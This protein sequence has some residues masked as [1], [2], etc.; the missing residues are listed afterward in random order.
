MTTMRSFRRV[1]PLRLVLSAGAAASV[2][3]ASAL[4]GP[5]NGH[6]VHGQGSISQNG[7]HTTV[8]AGNNSIFHWGS[9]SIGAGESVRFVQPGSNSRVLNRVTGPDPSRIAGQLSANGR[10]YIVNPAGVYFARGAVVNVG[11]IYAAAGSIS[12]AAFLSGSNTFTGLS[13][14]VE[15]RGTITGS[16]VHLI[17]QRVANYGTI[18][19]PEGMVALAAGEEVYVGKENGQI[20][21]KVTSGAQNSGGVGVTQAG[22]IDARGGQVA[23]GAGDMYAVAIHHTGR[24]T[25]KNITLEGG[26]KRG[27][28]QVA[29]VLDAANQGEEQ[30]GGTIKVLGE[31][32]GITGGTLDASGVHGGGTILVGGEYQGRG[33]TPTATRTVVSADSTLN[34]E[35]TGRGDGG[36]IIVWSDQTTIYKGDLSVRGGAAGGHGGFAEVSGKQSLF[37][38]GSAMTHSRAGGRDG[39]LLLDPR[40]IT[41]QDGV[42]PDDGEVS[43]SEILFGDGGAATDFVIGTDALEALTG[44]ILLQAQRDLTLLAGASLILA[45]QTAGESLTFIAGNDIN[46]LASIQTA[47]GSVI[48]RANDNTFGTATGTGVI[49]IGAQ[50]HAD[51]GDITL[52]GSAINLGADLISVGGHTNFLSPVVLTENVTLEAPAITFYSTLDSEATEFNTLQL[53]SGANSFRGDVGAAGADT[54]LGILTTNA[55]GVTAIDT[56]VL[57]AQTIAFNDRVVIQQDVTISASNSLI[58]GGTLNSTADEFNDL[59]LN[60]PS[61]R[62]NGV[63]GTEPASRLGTLATDA[64]GTLT[65]AAGSIHAD[66]LTIR[67]DVVLEEDTTLTAEQAMTIVGTIDSAGGETNDLTLDA[68]A[69]A[70][71]G[72]IGGTDALGAFATAGGVAFLNAGAITADTVE[73]GGALD[74]GAD[75]TITGATS[76][77]FG[78]IDSRAG[79]THDLTVNSPL[80]TFAGAAGANE[81]LGVVTTDA[82]GTTTLSQ[83]SIEAAEIRFNDDVEVGGDLNTLTGTTIVRF[84]GLVDGVG[85]A[86][87]QLTVNS[88]QTLF[89]GPIGSTNRLGELTTDAAGTT[90][91][92][93]GSIAVR[94]A[95]FEDTVVFTTDAV[96]NASGSMR[97]EGA[98]NSEAGEANTLTVQ[99]GQ[100]FFLSGL[101]AGTDGEFGTLTGDAPVTLGGEVTTTGSQVYNNAVRLADDT[102]INA[103]EIIFNAT[104]NSLSAD[105]ALTL[106]TSGNGLTRF[107]ANVGVVN[108]LASLTTNADGTT[109][110]NLGSLVASGEV[111]FNDPLLLAS[112]ATVFGGDITFDQTVDSL[113]TSNS[114]FV[115]TSGSGVTTFAG[116]VGGILALASLTTNPLGTTRIEGGAVTTTGQQ[117]YN[118]DVVITA[119]TTLTGSGVAFGKTLNSG[120]DPRSLTIRTGA[121]GTTTFGGAVGNT[122]Q[123]E[124]ITVNPDVTGPSTGIIRISGPTIRTSGD[125]LYNQR[126]VLG[127]DAAFTG[128]DISFVQ[129]LDSTLLLGPSDLT[130]N[131]TGGGITRLFGP[132]G[133]QQALGNITTNSDGRTILGNSQGATGDNS[134]INAEGVVAFNDSVTVRNNIDITGGA[135]IAFGNALNAA[136]ADQVGPDVRLFTSVTSPGSTAAP[137]IPRITF[138]NDVGAVA[139]L[140]SLTLGSDLGLTP[141]AATIGAGLGSGGTPINNFGLTF[142]TRRGF[143][144]GRG[145]KMTVLGDLTINDDTRATLSDINTLGSLTVNAPEIT[146]LRRPGGTNLVASGSSLSTVNDPGLDFIA[147]ESISFSATPTLAGE[148][149]R[150]RFGTPGGAGISGNLAEF[151][152]RSTGDVEVADLRQGANYLDLVA[153][154]AANVNL[155]TALPTAV[156]DIFFGAEVPPEEQASEEDRRQLAEIGIPTREAGP[157]ERAG[158]L[159]LG[160]DRRELLGF[161]S[162]PGVYIDVTGA[163]TQDRALAV[164]VSRLP[165]DLVDRVLDSYRTVFSR[166]VRD[167]ETGER[168][169]VPNAEHVSE[170]LSAAWDEYAA[171]AGDRA[172]GVGFR[173]YVEAVPTQAEALHYLNALRR[174]F[175]DIGYLGLTPAESRRAREAVLAALDVEG[176]TRQQLETA[177]VTLQLGR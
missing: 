156:P 40:D 13:G 70:L 160:A 19:A 21:A 11:G 22:T 154:G 26:R 4:A 170:V 42:G 116:E 119:D 67:D 64:G 32:V 51:V 54:A 55:A 43:D 92:G 151:S 161:L 139:P 150:P 144:M 48:L 81:A 172:D 53:N 168:S 140:G 79:Q 39:T 87:G 77:D 171:Q 120:L 107:N 24:T 44:N 138:T 74:L 167:P 148:G 96:L 47:G 17:G 165:A 33:D 75:A 162:A 29:G 20:F 134:S 112:N 145:H 14:T 6:L 149:A 153:T 7:A 38:T 91:I 83:A 166:E 25:A 95:L 34:A 163:G 66:R 82:A 101:G 126:V 177:I 173:A 174:L 100:F 5:E 118:D 23:L 127:G 16:A 93:G 102:T 37:F 49:N 121:T 36:R 28:V 158:G 45:N 65:V 129:G 15:N 133:A 8:H 135:G 111:T 63:V 115:N 128:N 176:M 159:A 18:V 98:V 2:L 152:S 104:V 110:L 113:G 157:G 27:I 89:V 78:A 123:L 80:T 71:N 146:L 3:A 1:N 88:P 59:S 41:I 56:A 169:H 12:N 141:A 94:T 108:P 125:Q 90:T 62:F 105:R 130:V 132:I 30:T 9:F 109:E 61:L 57:N 85:D 86:V 72:V 164:T 114:L 73:F 10:V 136:V 35:A 84:G 106:N 60:T 143:T 142:T 175:T 68:P 46:I 122:R 131:T 50:I 52:S 58:F 117:A 99:G 31:R 97:F 69:M 155:A 76:V 103:S 124:Q 137:G 147:G